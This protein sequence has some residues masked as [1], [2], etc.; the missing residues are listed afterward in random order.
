VECWCP[1]INDSHRT[2]KAV[3]RSAISGIWLLFLLRS[4]VPARRDALQVQKLEPK[5]QSPEP[6]ASPEPRLITRGGKP[7][8]VLARSAHGICAC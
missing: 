6:K 3:N 2:K 1:V 7:R 5:A 8:S 4:K